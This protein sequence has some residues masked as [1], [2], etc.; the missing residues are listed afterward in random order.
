MDV[1]NKQKPAPRGRHIV[2]VII[3]NRQNKTRMNGEI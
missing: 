3:D 2:A 1:V